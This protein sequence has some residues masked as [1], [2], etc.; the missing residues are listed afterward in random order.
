LHEGKYNGTVSW[1]GDNVLNFPLIPENTSNIILVANVYTQTEIASSND[2]SYFKIIF[3]TPEGSLT[4]LVLAAF[5]SL[6]IAR[7]YNRRK[8]WYKQTNY[9]FRIRS[10]GIKKI[11][12]N[13]NSSFYHLFRKIKKLITTRIYSRILK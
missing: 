4:I 9:S 5:T 11:L 1:R 10:E 2:L 13:T 6:L 12:M 3:S 7:A 8:P